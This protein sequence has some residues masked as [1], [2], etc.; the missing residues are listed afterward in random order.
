MDGDEGRKVASEGVV[1][2]FVCMEVNKSHEEPGGPGVPGGGGRAGAGAAGAGRVSANIIDH[3]LPR[4]R[5]G[6][7]GGS[8]GEKWPAPRA[9]HDRNHHGHDVS[10]S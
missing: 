1:G 2:F 3:R 8:G 10:S 7:G 5:R 6:D 9:E 4:P